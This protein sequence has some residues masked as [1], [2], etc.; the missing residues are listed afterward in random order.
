MTEQK[1]KEFLDK[2]VDEYNRPSFIAADPVLIPHLFTKKQDQE[3]A[4]FF[5]ATFAWGNR[6]TIINKSRELLSLMEMQPHSFCLHAGPAELKKLLSFKHRTFNPTDLLYFI[7]FFRHHYHRYDSLEA[8]FTMHGKTV[9]EMLTGFY[10]YFF[11]LE[12]AHRVPVNM[13]PRLNAVPP[14]NDSICFS[15]GWSG[16]MTAGSISASGVQSVLR[17]LSAPSICM[18]DG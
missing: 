7:D 11:S 15:A 3:I 12:D 9:E 5:A 18:W 6:T 13:L 17:N 4:G 10:H 1:L 8:A 14:A 16:M 2:K